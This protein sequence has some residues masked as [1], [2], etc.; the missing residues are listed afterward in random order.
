[1]NTGTKAK[2]RLKLPLGDVDFN[3]DFDKIIDRKKKDD[4]N[5]H[6]YHNY[7]H[8][9][10]HHYH[11][12]T[13]NKQG[14]SSKSKPSVLN[15]Q[16]TQTTQPTQTN[17]TKP[18]IPIE[19]TKSPSAPD[20]MNSQTTQTYTIQSP[21]TLGGRNGHTNSPS[22]LT[23]QSTNPF[24]DP[25]DFDP[26]ALTTKSTNPFD[27]DLDTSIPPPPTYSPSPK[28]D[29]NDLVVNGANIEHE[30]RQKGVRR[31]EVRRIK[32]YLFYLNSPNITCSICEHG[33]DPTGPTTRQFCH[34]SCSISHRFHTHC[35]IPVLRQNWAC[36]CC[37]S[38]PRKRTVWRSASNWVRVK[39]QPR[40]RTLLTST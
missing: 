37:K 14:E 16:T 9:Y 32:K 34:L 29:S 40:S 25:Y 24:D 23:I 28:P 5:H 2:F 4:S 27:E 3:V 21:T 15:Q 30:T 13:T 39:I 22:A 12:Q 31:N 19:N 6:Y 17:D 8:N 11:H 26:F 18:T 35:L 20:L 38:I 36:P 33:F 7:N 1:M 10:N